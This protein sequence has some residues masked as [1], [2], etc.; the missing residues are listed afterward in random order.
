MDRKSTLERVQKLGFKPEHYF[1]SS[2]AAAR[3]HNVEQKRDSG[4][5]HLIASSELFKKLAEKHGLVPGKHDLPAKVVVAPDVEVSTKFWDSYHGAVETVDGIPVLR[6]GKLNDYWS[7]LEGKANISDPV[8][9]EAKVASVMA[10]CKKKGKSN[11]QIGDHLGLS[12]QTVP[13]LASRLLRIKRSEW[14]S[15]GKPT[16]EAIVNRLEETNYNWNVI[17]Q[18]FFPKHP[19]PKHKVM[20]ILSGSPEWAAAKNRGK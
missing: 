1:V 4:K 18:E 14:H 15:M 8:A 2:D 13:S 19:R 6:L 5:I 10:E 16:P 7:T 9:I 12:E 17:E 3:L 20:K 11:R